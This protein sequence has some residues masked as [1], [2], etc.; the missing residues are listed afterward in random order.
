MVG[1]ARS[2]I[3]NTSPATRQ[4]RALR[5]IRDRDFYLVSASACTSNIRIKRADSLPQEAIRAN[6]GRSQTTSE[7]CMQVIQIP[8]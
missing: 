1:L 5:K 6:T 2:S 4:Q 8:C 7:A 3:S